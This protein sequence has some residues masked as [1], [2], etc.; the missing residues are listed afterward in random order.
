M[1]DGILLV[2]AGRSPSTRTR[3][4]RQ[5]LQDPDF[6]YF[7]GIEP[8]RA[9]SSRSTARRRNRFSS[10][11]RNCAGLAT[12]ERRPRRS[13]RA[14]PRATA[15]GP[16]PGPRPQGARGLPRAPRRRRRRGLFL[17]ARGAA[18]ART[19]FRS[20][21]RSTIPTPRGT[22]PSASSGAPSGSDPPTRLL[23]EMR[24][25]KSAGEIDA[26]RR[27]GAASATALLAG[28]AALR[29]AARSAR[30]RRP[31]FRRASPPARRDRPS[32]PG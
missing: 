8:R 13:L 30:P 20:T 9:P 7:T 21:S 19:A 15:S 31:S 32:G 5:F 17:Y 12:T 14:T 2:T 6:F 3:L 16:R 29:P 18:R 26:L 10:C 24:A 28:M 27:V 22:T 4:P 25:I 11:R 23:G 1:P